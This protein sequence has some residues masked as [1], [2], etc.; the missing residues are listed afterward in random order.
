MI[1]MAKFGIGQKNYDP[2]KAIT[3]AA[4]QGRTF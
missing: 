2:E 3:C 4:G 1:F